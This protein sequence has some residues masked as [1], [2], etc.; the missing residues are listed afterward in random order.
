MYLFV[1]TASQQKVFSMLI[2]QP[3]N[4]RFKSDADG[5]ALLYCVGENKIVT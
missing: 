2:N 4:K 3:T 1:S 5:A